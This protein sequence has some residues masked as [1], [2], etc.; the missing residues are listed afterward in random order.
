M[1]MSTEFLLL[2]RR[3]V[4]FAREEAP[5]ICLFTTLLR[6]CETG[7]FCIFEVSSTNSHIT[8]YCGQR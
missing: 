5:Y 2:T 3:T 8:Q 4:L 6:N 1:K 7:S